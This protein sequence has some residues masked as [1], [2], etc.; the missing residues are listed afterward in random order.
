MGYNNKE[1]GGREVK[2]M[3][4][5]KNSFDGCEFAYEGGRGVGI[6]IKA[7]HIHTHIRMRKM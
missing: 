4:L 2:K 1:Y 3:P 5:R 6:G 7:T